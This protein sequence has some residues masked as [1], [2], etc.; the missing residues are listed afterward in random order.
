MIESLDFERYACVCVS[1]HPAAVGYLPNALSLLEET[2]FNTRKAAGKAPLLQHVVA[3][4]DLQKPLNV[5]KEKIASSWQEQTASPPVNR[6]E[7]IN[8]FQDDKVFELGM[9]FPYTNLFCPRSLI[10]ETLCIFA[11]QIRK[12]YLYPYE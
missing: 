3:F 10:A 1:G 8:P 12:V 5:A 11:A 9:I 2:N 7:Q 4:I 6:L